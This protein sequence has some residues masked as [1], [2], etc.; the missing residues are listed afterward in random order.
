M[1]RDHTIVRQGAERDQRQRL[2]KHRQREC[3]HGEASGVDL[4]SQEPDH[5]LV[6]SILFLWCTGTP[7]R[8]IAVWDGTMLSGKL[9][10]GQGQKGSYN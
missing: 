2:D 7:A 3:I 10:E 1:G 4:Q 6:T 8:L 9:F 5:T